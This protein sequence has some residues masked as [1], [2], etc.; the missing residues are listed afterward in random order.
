MVFQHFHLFHKTVIENITLAPIL[1][2][3]LTKKEAEEKLLNS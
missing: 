3:Q 1:T 2:G